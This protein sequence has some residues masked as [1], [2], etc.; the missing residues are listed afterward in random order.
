ME[1]RFSVIRLQIVWALGP[2]PLLSIILNFLEGLT[3]PPRTQATPS[4]VGTLRVSPAPADIGRTFSGGNL[5][6]T[7]LMPGLPHHDDH[8]CPQMQPTVTR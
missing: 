5:G 7:H 2:G 8:R 3:H 1:S 4:M 6:P